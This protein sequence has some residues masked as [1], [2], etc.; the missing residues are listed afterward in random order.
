MAELIKFIEL[1]PGTIKL[2]NLFF[3]VVFVTAVA[4]LYAKF[5][6]GEH[7]GKFSLLCYFT[8]VNA[9]ETGLHS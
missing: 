6:C 5:F 4:S 8:H 3:C 9:G 2:F 7:H 1:W